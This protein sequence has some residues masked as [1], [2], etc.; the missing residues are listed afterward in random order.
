MEVRM[1]AQTADESTPVAG[2]DAD[3]PTAAWYAEATGGR[4]VG[5][6]PRDEVRVRGAGIDTRESLNGRVFVALRGRHADGHDHLEAATAAGASMLLVET[7]KAE[8]CRRVVPSEIPML[9]VADPRTALATAARAWRA[10][11]AGRIVA[12]TGSCGKTTTKRLLHAALRRTLRGVASPRSFNNDLGV[13][14]TLLSI[15]RHADYAVLEVGTSGPGE[16]A[17]LASLVRPHLAIIT[18][19]GRA[20]L[21]RLG[22]IEGIAAEKASLL[23]RLTAPAVAVVRADGG[24]LEAAVAARGARIG[25]VVTFGHAKRATVRV[26]ER[27]WDSDAQVVRLA[28]GRRFRLRLPG[29]H[30]AENAAAA[31]AAAVRLGVSFESA[32]AGIASV[33]AEA[34]RS[35]ERIAGGLRF[36]DDAYNANPDSMR[37][38]LEMVA[39]FENDAPTALVLG[40]MLEL[41]PEA[42]AMHAAMGRAVADLAARRPVPLAVFVGPLSAEAADAFEAKATGVPCLRANEATPELA[43]AIADRLEPGTRVLLKAS[44]GIGLERIVEWADAAAPPLVEVR[45]RPASTAAVSSQRD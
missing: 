37:A 3:W 27:R 17:Q 34:H 44:R 12:V 25:E 6:P 19:V 13:P 23:D 38:A 29:A 39:E 28:D 1:E 2:V 16:I 20:H 24:V 31:I 36:L 21:E 11:L 5:L 32:A 8:R 22:S 15:P 43:R 40:D 18:M 30:Q 26:V 10:T 14:L 4:W 35:V 41:G 7:T 33:E 9:A 42:A 45:S